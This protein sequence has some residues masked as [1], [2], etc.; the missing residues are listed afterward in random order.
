LSIAEVSI[1]PCFEV[2]ND[3]EGSGL[4]GDGL[5]EGVVAEGTLLEVK[6]P[7]LPRA[8]LF[9]DGGFLGTKQNAFHF[10]SIDATHEMISLGSK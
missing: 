8:V 2:A 3:N 6:D 4:L 1:L 5:K 7:L 10:S 9:L